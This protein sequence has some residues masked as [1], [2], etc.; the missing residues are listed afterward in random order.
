MTENEERLF[1]GELPPS[2]FEV[3][4]RLAGK[5]ENP[6]CLP[7]QA[8]RQARQ[9]SPEQLASRLHLEPKHISQLE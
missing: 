1:E 5:I 3:E 7:I 4:S 9:I 2:L 8:L 6:S